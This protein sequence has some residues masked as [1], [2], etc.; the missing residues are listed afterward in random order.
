MIEKLSSFQYEESYSSYELK[1]L[2]TFVKTMETIS[3][4]M[5]KKINQKKYSNVDGVLQKK[6]EPAIKKTL[7]MQSILLFMLLN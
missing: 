3:L 4:I 1:I 7:V 2:K 5:T 6:I